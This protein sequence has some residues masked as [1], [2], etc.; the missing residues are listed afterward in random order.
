MQFETWTAGQI[1]HQA[2]RLAVVTGATGELGFATALALA[3][4]GAD[5]V[6][7]GSDETEGLF[8]VCQIR[9]AAPSALVRFEKL[10]VGNLA[11]VSA[12]AG[13]MLKAGR[14]IDVLINH[15]GSRI[16]VHRC[17]TADGFEF[18]LGS[19]YLGH[20]ALTGLLLPLLRRSR[21]PRVVQLSS[22]AHRIASIAFED[23][24]MEQGYDPWRAYCR[25]MLATLLFALELHT[26]SHAL[27]WNVFSAAAHA[28]NV[29]SGPLMSDC[30]PRRMVRRLRGS[31]GF[32]LSHSP[33]VGALPALYAA[34]AP[35]VRP[36]SFYGPTGAFEMVGAPGEVKIGNSARKPG[37]ARE[38]WELSEQ[39]TGVKWPAGTSPV[40]GELR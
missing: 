19:N 36:G 3:K 30:N 20:F 14:P 38:L 35:G 8:A 39:V 37:L 5:V 24:Q 22:V 10:E 21:N 25:S 1:P 32:L 28:G 11:S 15:V 17:V 13:R 23:L 40:P 29:R 2:G 6:L 16:P 12:F 26:R 34:T 9:P 4:A 27:G 31:F 33:E 18:L 7:A